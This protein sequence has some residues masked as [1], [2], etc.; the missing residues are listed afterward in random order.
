[1][2]ESQEAPVDPEVEALLHFAPVVRRCRRHD[3]WTPEAQ[4]GFIVALAR[5]GTV[6]EAAIA[7]GRTESGAYKVRTSAGAEAF[8]AAW[9]GAVALY[10][11]RNPRPEPKG[12]PSRGEIL[13]GTGRKPWPGPDA[14]PPPP[15][16]EEEDR[17]KEAMFDSILE[18]Y[19]LK[20]AAERNARLDGQIV[21]ADFYVRQL[22]WLEVVLD[23]GGRGPQLLG[24]LQQGHVHPGRIVATPM[25]LLLDQARRLLWNEAGEPE[26]P[27]PP[28]LGRHVDGLAFGPRLECQR[29]CGDGL[30]EAAWRRRQSE[31]ESLAAEAQ[32]V[33]EEK[34]AAEAAAWAEREGE[35]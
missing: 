20:L 8:A 26:R 14:A 21:A 2:G 11:R 13:S 9:D 7:V 15:D 19:V 31:R 17:E 6:W 5:L 25:S 12:R 30:T 22:S 18:K 4:R 32:R 3:G 33:W 27:E 29:D 1:M 35:G 24:L 28:E 16:P 34:A 10:H 23:L